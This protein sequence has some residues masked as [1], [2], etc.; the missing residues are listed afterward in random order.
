MSGDLLPPGRRNFCQ[1]LQ[2]EKRTDGCPSMEVWVVEDM[3]QDVKK[4]GGQGKKKRG[5]Q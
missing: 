2:Y 3:C 1:V 4:G 5:V